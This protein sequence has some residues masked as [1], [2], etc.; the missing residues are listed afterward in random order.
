MLCSAP[1][2]GAEGAPICPGETRT[3][4]SLPWDREGTV[5]QEAELSVSCQVCCHHAALLHPQT[6]LAIHSD[7]K[8]ACESTSPI[9]SI[10]VGDTM[11]RGSGFHPSPSNAESRAVTLMLVQAGSHPK[12]YE[13]RMWFSGRT[14]WVRMMVGLGDCEGLFQPRSFHDYGSVVEHLLHS[15]SALLWS[16]T[17][18]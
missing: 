8:Q 3:E 5:G 14:Q 16:G 12:R 2:M 11:E 13:T 7:H 9:T 6:P 18:V 17:N 4:L 1:C 15:C 10:N